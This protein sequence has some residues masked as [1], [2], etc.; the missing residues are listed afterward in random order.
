MVLSLAN[1]KSYKNPTF[2]FGVCCVFIVTDSGATIN[3]NC[4]Y[5]RNPGYPSPYTG[6]SGVSYT[7][8]KCSSGKYW[9]KLHVHYIIQDFSK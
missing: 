6:S 4:T 2:R 7:I 3:Q 8:N 1:F 9:L 5:I